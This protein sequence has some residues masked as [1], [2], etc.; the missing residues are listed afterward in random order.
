M[1][2]TSST[3]AEYVSCALASKEAIWLRQLLGELQQFYDVE[4][5]DSITNYDD[6]QYH[7]DTYSFPSDQYYQPRKSSIPTTTIYCDN[8]GATALTKN[9]DQ[10]KKTKHID[11]A[12]HFVRER[13]EM[14]E[15]DIVYKS[16]DEM[17]ADD[18]TKALS[19]DKHQKHLVG[20]GIS[21][22]A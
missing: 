19:T 8:N 14:G 9:P 1:V 11:I 10:M 2:A 5:Y 4:E 21:E 17:V 3:E 15:L 7:E 22:S 20:M 18:L 6:T 16:T 13:V 12:Y